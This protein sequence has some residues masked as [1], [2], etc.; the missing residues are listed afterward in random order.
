[1]SGVLLRWKSEGTELEKY[2][3]QVGRR[4]FLAGLGATTALVASSSILQASEPGLE[5]R[6]RRPSRT[7]GLKMTVIG[8]GGAGARLAS[9]LPIHETATLVTVDRP[10]RPLRQRYADLLAGR[11]DESR[12]PNTS[13]AFAKAQGATEVL[14]PALKAHLRDADVVFLVGGV[15]GTTTAASLPVLARA[16]RATGAITVAAAISPYAFEGEDRKLSA[17]TCISQ[18][19]AVADTTVVI[20]NQDLFPARSGTSAFA[21]G[22]DLAGNIVAAGIETV[23]SPL[24]VPGMI[25]LDFADIETILRNRGLGVMAT[26]TARGDRRAWVAANDVVTDPFVANVRMRSAQHMLLNISGGGDLTLF[27]VDEAANRIYSELGDHAHLIFSSS[28][29]P[30]MDGTIR[31]SMIATGLV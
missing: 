20:P 27:E 26:A 12:D 21:E 17:E 9:R 28:Y 25:S 24:T 30:A 18:L 3:T 23:V 31:V 19:K 29:D 6:A 15:G 16:A 14:A 13:R 10:R 11:P 22:L 5:M 2:L 1:M 8:V 4:R 7:P